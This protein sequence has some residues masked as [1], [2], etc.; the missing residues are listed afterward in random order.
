MKKLLLLFLCLTC[1]LTLSFSTIQVFAEEETSIEETEQ[2]VDVDELKS[3]LANA[4]GKL[5]EYTGEDNFFKNKILPYII[6]GGADLLIVGLFFLRP[7]LKKKSL[8]DK[9]TGAA[10]QL[11]SENENLQALLKSTDPEEIKNLL[12]NFI[13]EAGANMLNNVKD[14]VSNAFKVYT[15][16]R[17]IIETEY[18]MLKTFMEAARLAWSSRPDVSEILALCPEKTTLQELVASNERLKNYIR[19][20]KGEEAESIL[21]ELSE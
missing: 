19:E 2:T 7:Y 10:S 11:Q 18:T 20:L 8:V 13:G 21:S 1:I 6:N 17:T 3:E 9:L 14:E 5:N 4:I 12:S 16:I 15:E